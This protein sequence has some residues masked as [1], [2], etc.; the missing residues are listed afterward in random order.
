MNLD[1]RSN[2]IRERDLLFKL[3]MN[4]LK[5]FVGELHHI[6]YEDQDIE[7]DAYYRLAS[8]V[9]NQ[10]TNSRHNLLIRL[11]SLVGSLIFLSYL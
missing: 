3:P 10:R 11:Q 1:S 2:Y 8:L 6:R 4:N 5:Q 7:V 9:L